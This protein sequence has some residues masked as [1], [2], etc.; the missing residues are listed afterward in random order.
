MGKQGTLTSAADFRRTYNE[1]KR[2]AARSIVAHVRLTQDEHP[3]R[4]GVTTTR[5]LGGAVERNRVKRRLRA[6]VRVLR[7]EI[8]QG[9]DVVLVGS[10][11]AASAEFQDLVYKARRALA[12]AGGCR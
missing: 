5:G 8:K 9:A 7:A 10:T 6:A 11:G 1:G 12:E 2:G 4:I 3:P